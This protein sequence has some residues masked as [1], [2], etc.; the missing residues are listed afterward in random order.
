M[1]KNKISSSMIFIVGLT[2]VVGLIMPFYMSNFGY[3]GWAEII[4]RFSSVR[5]VDTSNVRNIIYLYIIIFSTFSVAFLRS[6]GI[7][8]LFLSVP[9]T[10]QDLP[11]PLKTSPRRP[12]ILQNGSKIVPRGARES[13]RRP[14]IQEKKRPPN[15]PK[16]NSLQTSFL[17]R[18]WMDFARFSVDLG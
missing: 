8:K 6:G 9:V 13:P 4:R 12:Q 15:D 16:L 7:V 3:D 18:F 17:D 11:R 10:S 2:I 14:K 5:Y 1:G